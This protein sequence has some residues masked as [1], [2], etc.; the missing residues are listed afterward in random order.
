MANV[1][2]QGLARISIRAPRREPGLADENQPSRMAMVQCW[3]K[4]AMSVAFDGETI[5]HIMRIEIAWGGKRDGNLEID[6]YIPQEW[7]AA[8]IRSITND[9]ADKIYR[10]C[11]TTLAVQLDL[12]NA[13]IAEGDRYIEP[14]VRVEWV[15]RE[16]F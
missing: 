15:Q 3:A 9:L 12:D 13:R 2:I 1:K 11:G 7:D 4:A 16:V 8:K 14:R 6:V 10:E 5:R